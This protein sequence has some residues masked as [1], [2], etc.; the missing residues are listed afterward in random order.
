MVCT[1]EGWQLRGPLHPDRELRD[2]LEFRLQS[3]SPEELEVV[4]VLAVAEL[5]DWENLSDI[6][7]AEAMATLERRGLIQLVADG[8]HTLAQ[9]NHPMLGEAAIRYAGTVRVRQLNG[10][11]AKT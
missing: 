9:L 11:L 10:L 8:S 6:C 3:L 4:E 7:D 5:L 1:D 2:V